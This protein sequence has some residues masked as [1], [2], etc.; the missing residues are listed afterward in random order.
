MYCMYFVYRYR[1]NSAEKMQVIK[2]AQG[3]VNIYSSKIGFF[4]LH[5]S[6]IINIQRK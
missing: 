4:V 2:F 3:Y 6:A 1:D 5:N